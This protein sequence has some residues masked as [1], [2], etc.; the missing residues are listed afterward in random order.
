ML[1]ISTFDPTTAADG[2]LVPFHEIAVAMCRVDRP[3]DSLPS[4]DTVVAGLRTPYSGHRWVDYRI[5]EVDGRLCGWVTVS[6]PYPNNQDMAVLNVR[7]HPDHRRRGIGTRLLKA[8][9][10]TVDRPIVADSGMRKD[11]PG[12]AWG[13]SLGLDTAQVMAIQTRRLNDTDRTAPTSVPEGYRITGWGGG[14]PEALLESYARARNAL[15]DAPSGRSR[16]EHRQWTPDRIREVEELARDR[17]VEQLVTVA[18]KS[19][20]DEVVASTIV[21]LH[22][23][24]NIGFV[25]STAVT[26]AHRG[27]ALGRAVKMELHRRLATE[28]RDITKVHTSVNSD[29]GYMLHVNRQLGYQTV[30][31]IVTFE[32]ETAALSRRLGLN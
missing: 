24:R 2:D 9:M 10:E 12:H 23:G 4:F 13:L 21:E 22:P 16:Q 31:T 28:R 6:L 14:T 7:V 8:A 17:N 18:L 5:A 15:N 30:S 27:R 26:A 25:T 11:G 1:R 3:N 32:G 20:T 19:G 29:N